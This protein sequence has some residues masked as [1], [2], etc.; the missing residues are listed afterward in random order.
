MSEAYKV[1]SAAI[2]PL[3]QECRSLVDQIEEVNF[4]HVRREHNKRAD[5]L[6]NMA[7]DF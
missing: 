2:K 1:K 7:L 4:E 6:A 5:Q 3:F